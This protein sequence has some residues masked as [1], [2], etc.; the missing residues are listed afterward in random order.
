MYRRILDVGVFLVIVAI[1]GYGIVILQ[2][3]LFA[4]VAAVGL[5]L[6]YAEWKGGK[7]ERALVLVCIWGLLAGAFWT[8]RLE[9]ELGAIVVAIIGYLAWATTRNPDEP[10]V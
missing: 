9:F 6:T 10:T 2:Q 4:L 8:A 1:L 7:A 5:Y 3:V